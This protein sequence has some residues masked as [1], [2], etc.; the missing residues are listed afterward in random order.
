[1][2][3]VNSMYRV[4]VDRRLVGECGWE[5]VS[6]NFCWLIG[7]APRRARILV[8]GAVFFSAEFPVFVPFIPNL[9]SNFSWLDRCTY[10]SGTH[11]KAHTTRL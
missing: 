6:F 11:A 1:M 8:L 10:T 9:L 3:T 7:P 5:I 4:C 2:I